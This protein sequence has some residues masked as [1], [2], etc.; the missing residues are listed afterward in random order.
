MFRKDRLSLR[1][2]QNNLMVTRFV[3]VKAFL[4]LITYG[5]YG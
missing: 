1:A 4:L 5:I 2:G 3:H